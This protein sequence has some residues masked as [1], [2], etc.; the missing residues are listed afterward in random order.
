MIEKEITLKIR[1]DEEICEKENTFL[2][3]DISYY[4]DKNMPEKRIYDVEEFISF[5]INHLETD[6]NSLKEWGYDIVCTTD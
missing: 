4:I 6:I 1:V 2:N 5:L 3:Y